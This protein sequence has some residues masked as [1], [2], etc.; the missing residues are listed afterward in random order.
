MRPESAAVKIAG[1]RRSG[2]AAWRG[3]CARSA[4]WTGLV[5]SVVTAPAATVT[6]T[7]Q[8]NQYDTRWD[9]GG[10]T[11]DTV[12]STELGM[13][14]GGDQGYTVAWKTFRTGSATS[15]T[16]REP[17]GGRRIHDRVNSYG[18]YYGELGVSLNGAAARG[19]RGRTGSAG[20]NFPF[21]RTGPITGPAG[22]SGRGT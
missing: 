6:Y 22:G 12:A 17:A 15:S 19:R 14:A 16:A 9:S 1:R 11:Y 21:G 8:Q 3:V 10:G 20:R 5:F 13:W 2:G 4:V 18:V 7:Q